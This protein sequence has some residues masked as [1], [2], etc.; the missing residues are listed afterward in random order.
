LPRWLLADAGAEVEGAP[1]GE[2]AGAEEEAS[3]DGSAA[4]DRHERR[5]ET[6]LKLSAMTLN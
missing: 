5:L 2:S 3:A 6:M 4:V 1:A